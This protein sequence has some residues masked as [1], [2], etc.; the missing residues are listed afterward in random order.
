MLNIKGTQIGHIKNI[1]KAILKNYL[2]NCIWDS[3]SILKMCILL[4]SSQT[5]HN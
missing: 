3:F 4:I 2:L 1:I 5:E